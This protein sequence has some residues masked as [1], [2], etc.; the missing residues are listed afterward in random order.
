MCYKYRTVSAVR[1]QNLFCNF[2]LF[3]IY[4]YIDKSQGL[5][6]YLNGFTPPESAVSLVSLGLLT[7]KV[8][9][10]WSSM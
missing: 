3:F 5:N 1:Y 6:V 8:G 4:S 7:I 10:M 9:R 2:Y